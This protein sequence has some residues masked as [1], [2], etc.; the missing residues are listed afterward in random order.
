M[1]QELIERCVALGILVDAQPLPEPASSDTLVA[2]LHV[3]NACN[4]RCT[5][6]YLDKTDEAMSAET[7]YAA[8]DANRALGAPAR[9]NPARSS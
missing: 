1:P 7:G 8:V 4:L 9:A 3:T 6:C 5:Y 2:W